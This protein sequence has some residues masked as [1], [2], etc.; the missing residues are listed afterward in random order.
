M[1]E[2]KKVKPVFRV[3]ALRRVKRGQEIKQELIDIGGVWEQVAK[4]GKKYYTLNL[5][6]LLFP[7]E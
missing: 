2:R 6:I 5:S 7:N 4:S 3:C 1:G